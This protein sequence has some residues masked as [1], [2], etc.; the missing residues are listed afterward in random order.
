MLY[1]I[2]YVYNINKYPSSKRSNSQKSKSQYRKHIKVKSHVE[3]EIIEYNEFSG[4]H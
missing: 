3:Q 2:K 4:E 1:Y